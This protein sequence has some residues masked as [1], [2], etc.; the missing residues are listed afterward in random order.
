MLEESRV[1]LSSSMVRVLQAQ[2][3]PD[4][5]KP[6]FFSGVMGSIN[7]CDPLP[8]TECQVGSV[9]LMVTWLQFPSNI[10]VKYN[11]HKH[12]Q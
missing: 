12:R 11:V 4:V 8:A 9:C 2:G 10:N 3:A 5:L 1:R 7:E 6:H